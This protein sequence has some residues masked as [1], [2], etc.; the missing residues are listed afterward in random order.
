MVKGEVGDHLQTNFFVNKKQGNFI[1]IL[2]T[3]ELVFA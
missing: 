1:L 3:D 2:S